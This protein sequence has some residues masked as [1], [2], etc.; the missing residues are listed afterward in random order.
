M[1]HLAVFSLYPLPK[2]AEITIPFEFA[3]TDY[4]C[5]LLCA[6]AQDT[7][8]VAK[9]KLKYQVPSQELNSIME[10]NEHNGHKICDDSS[11]SSHNPLNTSPLRAVLSTQNSFQVCT[12]CRQKLHFL[13]F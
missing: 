13:P 12:F 1:L 6:C 5:Y 10:H 7:C 4:N 9:Y 11:N 2:G 8:A 3:L